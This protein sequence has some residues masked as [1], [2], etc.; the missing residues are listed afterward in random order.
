MTIPK[1]IR[2]VIKHKTKVSKILKIDLAC[3]N[4]KIGPE[5][6]GVD[7]Q[8]LPNVDVAWDLDVYPWPFPDE[9]AT[10][11]VAA[12]Y[13]EHINPSRGGFIKFMDEVWRIL[14]VD[15]E[16]GIAAP[17]GVNEN[18]VQDPTHCNPVNHATF[19]YFD[20][21]HESKYY[22]IY[23]PKPWKIKES[24]WHSNGNIEEV[25]VKRKDIPQYYEDINP[26]KKAYLSEV[27]TD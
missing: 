21:L 16:F 17:Y 4:F 26:L 27:N 24:I 7:I 14:K 3:G 8:K 10:T 22:N 12:H 20:P 5:W 9:C 13:V 15:G 18:Y 6:L 1:D 19:W 25:L 11:V 23:H 2:E